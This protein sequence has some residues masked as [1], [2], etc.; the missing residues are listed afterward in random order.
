MRRPRI[1]F[2]CSSLIVGG[3]EKQWSLLIPALRSQF[4]V[5]VLTLVSEGPFF[6]ELQ[7]SGI[8]TTCAHMRNR[9]DLRG[10]WRAFR[11]ASFR[12]HLTVT[13]SINAHVV[14]HL[15]A[16]RTGAA[17][18]T[19][20]HFGPGSPTRIHRQALNRLVGPRVDS[21]IVV[22]DVQIPELVKLGYRP[23]MIR[24]IH[25]GVPAPIPRE[26]AAVVRARLGV[27]PDEFLALLVATLRPEKSVHVFIE[28]VR[29]ANRADPRVRGVIAGGGS[30]LERAKDLAGEDRVVQVLGERLDV[31]DLLSAADASCLSSTAE[32]VPMALLEA[33]ALAKPV[34]ATDVGGVSSAVEAEKTGLLV[35]V[36]DEKAFAEALVRLAADP[37]FAR[38]LGEAGR[39]RH[40]E[41]FGIERM[42]EEYARVFQE[43]LEARDPESAPRPVR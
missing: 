24:V 4:D 10:L 38:E 20:E 12:P 39:E 28:A 14:G 29:R 7:S 30:E 13:Q 34:I 22:S 15:I 25:N 11:L 43:T 1:L 19:N 41:F 27:R 33:M 6:E 18:V 37:A 8:P 26:D 36:G 32:G 42:V 9:F 21:A 31:P 5:S 35:D 2:V 16:R 23:E 3:A 17:H 40:R